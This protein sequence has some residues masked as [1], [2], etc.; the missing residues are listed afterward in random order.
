LKAIE[1]LAKG[2]ENDCS[3]KLEAAAS[4]SKSTQTLNSIKI[5]EAM[6]KS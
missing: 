4:E 1:S 3:N 6:A 5:P 2:A